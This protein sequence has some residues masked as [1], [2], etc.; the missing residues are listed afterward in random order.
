MKVVSH[1]RSTAEQIRQKGHAVVNGLEFRMGND[2]RPTAYD[3]SEAQ[4]RSFVGVEGFSFYHDDGVFSGSSIKGHIKAES[5]IDAATKTL[6][7]AGSEARAQSAIEGMIARGELTP[8]VLDALLKLAPVVQASAAA[9]ALFMPSEPARPTIITPAQPVETEPAQ[10]AA[11]AQPDS[12]PEATPEAT[13]EPEAPAGDVPD[14]DA[15][16]GSADDVDLTSVDALLKLPRPE[17]LGL[18]TSYKVRTVGKSNADVAQGIVAAVQAERS[19]YEQ[20]AADPST[21]A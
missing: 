1:H 11:P 18:A 9:G 19:T 10:E 16:E 20:P 8:A 13:P 7:A 15:G 17:F 6:E 3:L 4:V 14:P 2:G 5:K 21:E 12:E